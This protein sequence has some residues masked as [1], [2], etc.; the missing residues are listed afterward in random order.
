M[1]HGGF[2]RLSPLV[3]RDKDKIITVR[4][5]NLA[6]TCGW[7]NP[8]VSDIKWVS[9]GFVLFSV[10]NPG[11]SVSGG[12]FTVTLILNGT[13]SEMNMIKKQGLF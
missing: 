8:A 4:I 12:Q 1:G 10:A 6:T 13:N 3:L 2:C 11:V 7:N 9:S 5:T